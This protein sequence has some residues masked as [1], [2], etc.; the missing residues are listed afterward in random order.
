MA[1]KHAVEY[2]KSDRAECKLCGKKITKGAVRLGSIV[3]VKG[4]YSTKWYACSL[5]SLAF[6]LSLRQ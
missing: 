2:A 1:L 6:M 3:P 4:Y 5:L